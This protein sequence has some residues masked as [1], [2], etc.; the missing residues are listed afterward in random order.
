MKLQ[1]EIEINI[2]NLTF[3]CR[4]S[5]NK[6]DELVLLLH[7]FPQ[8][9]YMWRRLMNDISAQGHYCLAPDMRGYSKGARPSG[10]K[11]YT[12]EALS[13][14]VLDIVKHSGRK[15]F[16]LIGHDWGAVIGWKVVHDNPTSILSWT[17]MSI[18]HWQAFGHA[19][20]HDPEQKKM[21]GYIKRFQWPILPEVSIR[22]NDFASFRKL[23]KC[24]TQDEIE[25][26][27]SILRDKKA[28]TAALNYYRSNYKLLRSAA[29]RQILGEIEVPTL[30]IWGEHD[31]GIGRTAAGMN[32]QYMKGY[33]A[34]LKLDG[35][36]YLIESNY[37]GVSNAIK[38]HL[39][40]F[41]SVPARSNATGLSAAAP[42]S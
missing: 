38:Q 24:S 20:M 37:A 36:H 39:A 2:G 34:F 6:D 41:R 14:D 28:L 16:H 17:G 29:Q 22:K 31:F 26:Y 33:Y 5:G 7:G 11:H 32:H 9:S 40:K 35:G 42:L 23:W 21:S 3:D 10:K 19:V 27:L 18:P 4:V 13:K 12:M 15:R 30:F 8:S 1:D 25:N